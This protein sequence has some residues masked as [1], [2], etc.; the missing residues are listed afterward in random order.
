M[1]FSANRCI[2]K[3]AFVQ[4][5]VLPSKPRM[6]TTSQRRSG[7]TYAIGGGGGGNPFANM[8][9]M[10]EQIKKAQELVQVEAVKVQKELAETEFSGYDAEELVCVVLT[11]NQ[12]PVATDITEEA[13]ALGAE[14]LGKLVT[15]AYKEAHA[16][17][18]GAMKDR[19]R[20][21]AGKVGLPPGLGG[22]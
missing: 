6:R 14:E 22:Q 20:E 12:E 3:S 11:G 21:L 10:M 15:E 17:S 16:K 7:I 18:T 1:L 2:G 13:M 4:K 8:G 9:G 19:M 5:N